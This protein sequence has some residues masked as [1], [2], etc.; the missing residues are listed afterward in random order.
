MMQQ[1]LLSQACKIPVWLT[2][3]LIMQH[4]KTMLHNATYYFI[5]DDCPPADP[6]DQ[7]PPLS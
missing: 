5:D 6:N 3:M 7:T 1:N 2:I 4:F